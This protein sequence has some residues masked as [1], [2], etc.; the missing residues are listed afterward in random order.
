MQIAK[1]VQKVIHQK[2]NCFPIMVCKIY[3]SDATCEIALHVHVHVCTTIILDNV[4]STSLLW[5]RTL[6]IRKCRI[7]FIIS[8]LNAELTCC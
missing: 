6:L 2:D 3:M 4:I 8:D 5:E 7:I 1:I